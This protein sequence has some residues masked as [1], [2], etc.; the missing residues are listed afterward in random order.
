MGW[1]GGTMRSLARL[2]TLRLAQSR[3]YSAADP[4]GCGEEGAPHCQGCW[5]TLS[6]GAGEARPHHASDARIPGFL[7]LSPP[8]PPATPCR[9]S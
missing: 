1:G 4:G 9:V 8:G 6:P 5:G 2:L 7:V 3:A